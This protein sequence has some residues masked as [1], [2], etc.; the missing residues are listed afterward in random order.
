MQPSSTSQAYV[1]PSRLDLATLAKRFA[2]TGLTT[3]QPLVDQH[4]AL[5]QGIPTP[6]LRSPMVQ[7]RPH[8][9]NAIIS[10]SASQHGPGRGGP[11][12]YLEHDLVARGHRVPTDLFVSSHNHPSSVSA[13]DKRARLQALMPDLNSLREY[14]MPLPTPYNAA[15]PHPISAYASPGVNQAALGVSGYDKIL[16]HLLRND[17]DKLKGTILAG[18]EREDI[19]P[20]ALTMILYPGEGN[21]IP[22]RLWT[23]FESIGAARLQVGAAN[24]APYARVEPASGSLAYQ[25]SEAG[26]RAPVLG[27]RFAASQKQN[28]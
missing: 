10:P 23:R 21:G 18:A 1:P 28:W 25:P 9:D 11:A 26:L 22:E 15:Y 16:A 8:N 19:L 24:I 12:V 7:A 14:D 4:D 2:D 20:P 17:P 13:D 5:I 27:P 3:C 6:M